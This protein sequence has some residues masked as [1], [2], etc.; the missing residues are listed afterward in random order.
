MWDER[1][2]TP[3]YIYGTQPNDFLVYVANEIPPSKVLCLADGEGRN[4]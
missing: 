2:D 3:E 4:V 1:F